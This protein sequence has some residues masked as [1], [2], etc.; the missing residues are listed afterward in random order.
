MPGR[1]VFI[2]LEILDKHKYLDQNSNKS[3][4]S[5]LMA[6]ADGETA[7]KFASEIR[8][9]YMFL[10]VDASFNERPRIFLH[11][12]FNLLGEEC[13][14]K[15]KVLFSFNMNLATPYISSNCLVLK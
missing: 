2:N 7:N 1:I 13:C 11:S 3:N 5:N 8:I 12:T 4:S 6:I 10:S 9:L 15:L 14:T